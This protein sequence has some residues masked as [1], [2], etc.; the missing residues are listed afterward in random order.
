[1]TTAPQSLAITH[2]AAAGTILA[3]TCRGDGTADLVK[4][5]RWRWSR[6]LTA[7][8][9]PSLPRLRA[10]ACRDRSYGRRAAGRRP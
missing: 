7:W 5:L 9:L 3:G 10:P 8:Y 4:P 1:M 2:T 6:K